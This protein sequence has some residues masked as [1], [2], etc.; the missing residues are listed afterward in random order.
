MCLFVCFDENVWRRDNQSRRILNKF[1]LRSY[2]KRSVNKGGF[3][4]S[5]SSIVST[6]VGFYINSS[7]FQFSFVDTHEGAPARSCPSHRTSSCC[8]IIEAQRISRPIE[9]KIEIRKE[10]ARRKTFTVFKN[11]KSQPI[12]NS[13][14]F[15]YVRRRDARGLFFIFF[16][17]GE[18]FE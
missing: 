7:S 18:K 6:S 2:S 9:W 1:I 5:P 15:L 13:Y 12:K 4:L 17:S 8:D 10:R 14:R 3:K 11:I 16:F